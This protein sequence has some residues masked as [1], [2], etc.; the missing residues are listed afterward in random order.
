MRKRATQRLETRTVFPAER[1]FEVLEFPLLPRHLIDTDNIEAHRRRSFL[2]KLPH[3]S[4]GKPAQHI[5]LVL[6]DGDL[7]R[8]KIVRGARLYLDE[9]QHRSVPR[10]EVDVAGHIA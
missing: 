9:A 10:N 3:I 5:A 2:R 1:S 4:A 8:S 6:I 7:G